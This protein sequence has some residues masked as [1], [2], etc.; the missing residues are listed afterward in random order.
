M[1]QKG[2]A[3]VH[4]VIDTAMVVGKFL[5]AVGDAQVVQASHK[6]TCAVEQVKLILRAAVYIKCLELNR[7]AV[8]L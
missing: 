6:P 7:Y 2:Q 8:I 5:V 1:G 4:A 3:F